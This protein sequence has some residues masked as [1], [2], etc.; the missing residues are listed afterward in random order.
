MDFVRISVAGFGSLSDF[1]EEAVMEK[2]WLK[3]Y[4][5]GVPATVDFKEITLQES[6]SLTAEKLPKHRALIFQGKIINYQELDLMV[7]RFAAALKSL[8][9][10]AG[11]R[12]GLLMPNL[13]QTVV[14]M[15]GAFRVG[16]IAVPNNPLYTD[17]ELEYQ[18]RDAGCHIVIC[19]D[20]LVPR[21]MKM[22]SRTGIT[23]IISCHIRDYLPF[24]LKQ[25]FP[26]VKKS[27]HLNTPAGEGIYEFTHILKNHEP[28]ADNYP[29]HMDDTA[30]L[31][32]TGGTTGVSKGVELTHR[33][34][35]S[36]CQQAR[37]W[38][39]EFVDGQEIVLGGLPFFHSYGLTA[40]MI[41][42]VFYGWCNV[43]IPK[44]EARAILEAVDKYKVTFIPGVPTLFNAMINHPEIKKFSLASVKECLSAAAPLALE[45]I[46]GFQALTGILISEAYG[47]TETSPCTHAIPFGGKVKPGCIGLPVP[48]TDAKLVDVDD[49]SREVTVVGQPGE[50]CV[51]G[52]QVMKGYHNRPDETAAVLKDGWLLTGDI[53]TV[54]EDGYFTIVDR[55][56]DLIISGGFNIYPR[57]VDEVLFAHPKILEACTI[58]VPDSYSGERVKA[59]IVLKSEASATEQEIIDYCRERLTN[60]KVPKH[61]EFVSDLPKSPIGKILRKELRA[62]ELKN[63]G[64]A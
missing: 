58:G 59:F 34:L 6:L 49:Q 10:T 29:S 51:K 41:M 13:V 61:V 4:A 5:A 46:K 15:F 62:A 32:Y 2:I 30:V 23:K 17:R 43:L 44:P 18:L 16:A 47:L 8:G 20:T 60:Y 37:A 35:A 14:G 22:R 12:V 53:A 7:S 54:D 11:D 57:D 1:T 27:L 52:P 42:S 45:T 38:C 55:K 40:S 3:S 33:N 28:A 9:V 25:L 19:L 63:G 56:K 31:I 26:I 39:V 48:S 64:T 50:L 21:L 24:P 36:N